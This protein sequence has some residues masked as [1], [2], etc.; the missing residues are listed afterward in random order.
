MGITRYYLDLVGYPWI[1]I[2]VH[3]ISTVLDIYLL[4]LMRFDG[5]DNQA[6]TIRTFDMIWTNY[7]YLTAKSL[8]EDL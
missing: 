5:V 1:L 8:D 4:H 3:L 2:S 6:Y 7:I